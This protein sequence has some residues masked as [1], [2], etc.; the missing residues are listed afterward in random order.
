MYIC[1]TNQHELATLGASGTLKIKFYGRHQS[2]YS[3]FFK[4]FAK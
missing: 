4:Y 2:H 3:V 1:K